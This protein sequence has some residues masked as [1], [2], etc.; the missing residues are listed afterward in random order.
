MA[1]ILIACEHTGIVRDAFRA[2]GH[3]AWSCDLLP[4][5]RPGPHFQCDVLQVLRLFRGFFDLMI[6]HPEC[7]HLAVSGS[8]H[9]PAKRAD[10]RQQAAIDF[11]MQFAESEIPHVVIEQPI[12]IMSTV[13]RKPDQII[14]PHHFGHPEF[15]STCLWLKGLDKLKHTHAMTPPARDTD[16]WRKWNRVHRMA[17]GPDRWKLRSATYQGIADAMALQWGGVLDAKRY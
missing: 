9:F 6:A 7:T 10:G 11:F 13:W 5:L 12:S 2:R 4:T 8:R 17:P 3:N 16:E 15:K 1:N 14:Q